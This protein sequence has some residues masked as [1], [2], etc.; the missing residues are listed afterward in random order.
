MDQNDG[1]SI[2][3]D[4]YDT[5]DDTVNEIADVL[6]RPPPEAK[7]DTPLI[8]DSTG[9][10]CRSTRIHRPNPK[11]ANSAVSQVVSW[12]NCC[13]DLALVEAC[14][15]EVHSTSLQPATDALSWEPAPKTLRD[16]LWLP[17]G[18]VQNEWLNS[19]K[20]ELKTLVDSNTFSIE[21]KRDN[22]VI[23]PVMETFKVKIKSDGSFDKLKT[24][25]VVRGDL[26][27]KSITEDKWSPTASF[28]CL[29]MFLAHTSWLK[30]HV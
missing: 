20:W 6:Q 25:L 27:D 21:D 24:R 1:D 22:E 30:V 17:H 8:V 11:Y 5:D 10:L 4:E 26:Q 19:V 23:T 13:K 15:V 9:T 29:K 28:R 3:D 12:T 18:T 14:A 16:I 7:S 2:D